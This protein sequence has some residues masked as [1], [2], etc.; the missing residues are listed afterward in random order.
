VAQCASVDF[1]GAS[2]GIL[3]LGGYVG[4]LLKKLDDLG[5]ANNTIVVL[6]LGRTAA[7]PRS[8]ARRART[9]KAAGGYHA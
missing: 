1:L 4:Q 6:S 8:E 7:Q 2:P 5:V 9:G 3:K